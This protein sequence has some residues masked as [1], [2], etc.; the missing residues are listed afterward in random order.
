MR[1]DRGL[2]GWGVFLILVGAVPLAV[3]GGYLTSEQVAQA[4]SLWPL[5]LVGIGVGLVLTRTPL[6]W[7]G[8]IVVA[9]TLGLMIGALVAT[10]ARGFP[11]TV[12]GGGT[13]GTPFEARSGTLEAPAT[14]AIELDCGELALDGAPGAGWTV[15]GSSPQGAP[16]I[17]AGPD[18]LRLRSGDDGFAIPFAGAAHSWEV[19]IP[20]DVELDLAV[21]IDA[22]EGR[23]APGAARL[24][25]LAIEFNA[26][27]LVVDLSEAVVGSLVLEGNAGSAAVTLPAT[28][29]TGRL[30]VNAG[31][32]ELCAPPGVGLRLTTEDNLTASYDVERRDLVRSGDTWQTP[33]FDQADVRIDLRLAANAGSVTL[34][35][36][37]GCDG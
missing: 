36:E 33:G 32:I 14:I 30:E 1:I 20:R 3:R 15:S 29:M 2:L 9:A 24:G 19:T 4:W 17:E 13:A 7:V 12:C 11:G 23:I 18:S 22:G 8:G 5:I 16:A 35:P 26:G 34:D 28:S 37:G 10:G 21:G 31:S 25:D 6:E 27:S